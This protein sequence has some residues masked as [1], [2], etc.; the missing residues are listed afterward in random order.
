MKLVLSLALAG[1][2][3]K[4]G[5]AGKDAATGDAPI[6]TAIDAPMACTPSKPSAPGLVVN[7][8]PADTHVTFRD[9]SLFGFRDAF[10]RYPMPNRLEVGGQNLV[11]APEGCGFEDAV[12]VAVF[13]IFTIGSQSLSGQPTHLLDVEVTGPAFTQLRTHWTIAIPSACSPQPTQAAGNTSWSFFPDGKVVRNDTVTPG[14]MAA[15]TPGPSGCNCSG[16]S[17]VASALVTSY[18]TF[19]STLLS[20][21]TR[22]GE[23]EQQGLP[24]AGVIDSMAGACAR[25]TSMGKVAMFWDRLDN[26]DP[27]TPPTRLR[28]VTNAST[29]HEI[30]AFVYDMHATSP[31]VALEQDASFGIRT[32]LMLN[33][34]ARPCT[35]LLANLEGMATVQPV[36]IGPAGSLASVFYNAFGVFDDANVHS[37]AIRIEGTAPAGFAV[38][39]RFPGFTAVATDR[40]ADR[41]VW[42]RGT[43]GTFTLFFLDGIST[44][45]PIS[46]T[47]ECGS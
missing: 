22:S 34:G 43:D 27:P 36:M 25:G 29:S 7:P 5:F 13:P 14:D 15:V 40:P 20:A 38:R 46:V 24:P 18:A 39:L 31:G 8:D 2:F 37:G 6:D 19:E 45:S 32:H 44:Q 23:S 26:Q 12:G 28:R 17:G 16:A 35:D 1:C 42:Q 30:V 33:A 21:V 47:P 4:P 41:V 10:T 9:G 3:D 11:A